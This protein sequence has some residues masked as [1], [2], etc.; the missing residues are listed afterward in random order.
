MKAFVSWSGGKDCMLALHRIKKSAKYEISALINMCSD[1]SEKSRSHGLPGSLLRRQAFA[2]R[3]PILQPRSGFNN[4]ETVFKDTVLQ[5]KAEGVNYG[6]F[7]DI[8]LMEHRT[9]IERVCSETGIE[10]IFP[11]W[12]C[13]TTD[14]IHEFVDEGFN[15]LLV[16]V[17]QKFLTKEWLGRTI[18]SHFV[19]DISSFADL[20]PCA[21]NGE[22]HS[23]VH[24]G[25]IFKMP[26]HFNITSIRSEHNHW[27]LDL[28]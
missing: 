16:S 22:Y 7:G 19:K 28:E 2:I 3:T 17:N 9:W 25:P 1:T 14:L 5:L 12:N 27:F 24:D 20:D 21:E 6:V 15:A 11:L 8:Y 13:S 23:F 18:D 26:V 4:Y 10:P